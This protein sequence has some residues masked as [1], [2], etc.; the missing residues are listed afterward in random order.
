MGS[1]ING[2]PNSWMVFFGKILL[3]WM[4]WGYP[5]FRKPP[6]RY[7]LP[8]NQ[9]KS[10]LPVTGV[11]EHSLLENPPFGFSMAMAATLCWMTPVTGNRVTK[12]WS[13]Y[14]WEFQDS[15]WNLGL[16]NRP[17]ISGIGTSN[18][19]VPVAWPCFKP[20]RPESNPKEI[21]GLSCRAKFRSGLEGWNKKVP[22]GKTGI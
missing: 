20:Q 18:Q 6:Y 4:I 2:V 8:Q 16:K 9:S 7:N 12:R 10:S 1:S 13:C 19:S 5:F 14:Q 15:P 3:T 17:K 11:I 22:N 21:N